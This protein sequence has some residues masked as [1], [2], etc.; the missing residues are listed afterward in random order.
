MKTIQVSDEMYKFL[1]DLSKELNTQDHRGTAM[2]YFFQIQTTE[3]VPAAED[4][5]VKVW[6]QD[7]S[8]ALRTDEDIKEAV[9]EYKEWDLDSEVDQRAYSE[10]LSFEIDNILNKN[11]REVWVD[12]EK[13]YQNAFLTEK[14]CKEHIRLNNYHY[15]NPVDYLSYAYRN[16]ELEKVMEFLCGITG[17]TPHK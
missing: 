3:E 16:P 11:Y 14:A 8:I 5:G 12:E 7:G 9:F 2:P 6:V 17:G 1:E 13:K 10:L 4:C 15:S